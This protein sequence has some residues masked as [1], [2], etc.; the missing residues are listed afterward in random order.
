MPLLVAQFVK[1]AVLA[2]GALLS[3]ILAIAAK[4]EKPAGEPQASPVAEPSAG[5]S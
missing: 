4:P 5:E 1:L 3:L 2:G